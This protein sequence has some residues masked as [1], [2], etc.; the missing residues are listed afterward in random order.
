MGG[1]QRRCAATTT[2]TINTRL[3]DPSRLRLTTPLHSTDGILELCCWALSSALLI[4]RRPFDLPDLI[5]QVMC[6]W[7]GGFN[8]TL[9]NPLVARSDYEDASV[10]LRVGGG[11]HSPTICFIDECRGIRLFLPL[12]VFVHSR[13]RKYYFLLRTAA[14]NKPL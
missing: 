7:G 2:L 11:P 4:A 5:E 14:L 12:Y 13:V 10:A 3:P 1:R 6:G 8:C 9:R